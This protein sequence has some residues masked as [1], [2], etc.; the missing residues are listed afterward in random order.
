MATKIELQLIPLDRLSGQPFDLAQLPFAI[1]PGVEVADVSGLLPPAMFEYL[2]VEVGRHRMR[3]FD[4]QV[5]YALV[6]RYEEHPEWPHNEEHERGAKMKAALLNEVFACSRIV[7]PTRRLGSVSDGA[8]SY[9][10]AKGGDFDFRSTT[11]TSIRPSMFPPKTTLDPPGARC[12]LDPRT[13]CDES[14]GKESQRRTAGENR[15]RKGGWLTQAVF[16]LEWG[17]SEGLP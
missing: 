10:E 9:R 13:E 15:R 17:N 8:P 6:H 7:R 1:L 11:T 16:W 5:K 14:E 4:G 12:L 2:R 3:V